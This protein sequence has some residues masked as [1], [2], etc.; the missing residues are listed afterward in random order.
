MNTGTHGQPRFGGIGA[1]DRRPAPP[2]RTARVRDPA[3]EQTA[4]RRAAAARAP[5]DDETG[6]SR[7]VLDLCC[8]CGITAALHGQDVALVDPCA[9]RVRAGPAADRSGSSPTSGNG[10]RPSR[11][12]ALGLE[13]AA[14]DPPDCE[15]TG[16][17]PS[18]HEVTGCFRAL[19]GHRNC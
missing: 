5:L 12:C 14:C 7:A 4:F 18:G 17:D 16:C 8:S 19:Y 6:Q 10:R 1:I 9:R 2:P 15:V 13:P 3:H 11:R